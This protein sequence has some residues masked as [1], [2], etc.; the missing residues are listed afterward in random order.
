MLAPSESVWLK[1]CVQRA[2]IESAIGM[3][4]DELNEI[5]TELHQAVENGNP[6]RKELRRMFWSLMGT[7]AAA[8]IFGAL[9][10]Y[11][12]LSNLQLK[13][14]QQT[15]ILREVRQSV[16]F[17]LLNHPDRELDKRVTILE[18]RMDVLEKQ[19]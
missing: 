5:I 2:L 9:A 15:E 8:V 6:A 13:M 10:G 19:P 18:K 12:N 4:S 1:P 17:H 3:S 7:I 11:V 16:D 14:E